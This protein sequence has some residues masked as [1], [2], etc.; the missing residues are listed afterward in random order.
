MMYNQKMVAS[1]KVKGKILREIKENVLLPF[2]CE[3]SILLKN[4]NTVR[5]VVNVFIDGDNVVPGGIVLSPNQTVD[6]ERS[7]KNGNLTEGNKFKFIERTSAIEDGPRGIKLEDGLIR[8]EYQFEKYAAQTIFTINQQWVPGHYEY[9][10]QMY[11]NTPYFGPFLGSTGLSGVSG[12]IA[13]DRFSVTASGAVNQVN[14][15]GA[16]RG[17]D[18]SQNG[19]AMQASASAASDKYCADNGIHNK[20]E[21]HAG[22]ATMD[23]SD[24]TPKNDVGIT[25]AGGKSTQQFQTT[26]IGTLEIEK[27]TIVL[28]LLGETADNKPVVEPL[29]VKQKPK[30]ETCG[31]TN[32][33]TAHFCSK[34]GT[35]LVLYA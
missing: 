12:S 11:S 17:V 13:R 34:C 2:G 24:N 20:M 25:V 28:K 8:V 21:F 26:T 19:A 1:I 18:T 23:W 5:C 3:Y 31:T 35:S 7:I 32:K 22:A 14:V 9:D 30:C 6:L 10:K 27:H 4:L 29:T 16:L 15:G 33:A